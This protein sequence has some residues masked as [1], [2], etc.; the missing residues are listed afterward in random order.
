M[1]MA[2]QS[3]SQLAEHQVKAVMHTT[4]V[5]TGFDGYYNRL[6]YM[7]AGHIKNNFLRNLLS[8]NRFMLGKGTQHIYKM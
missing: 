4:V 6:V 5:K 1:R 7:T 2:Q 3:I 8:L